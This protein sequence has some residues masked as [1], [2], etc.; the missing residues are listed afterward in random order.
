V[1]STKSLSPSK[2]TTYL[3][4]PTKYRWTYVDPRGRI[5]LR[6]KSYFSFG[7]SLHRVLQRFHDSGDTGVTTLAEATAALEESWIDAGYANAEEMTQALAE[8]KEIIS[9]YVEQVQ[10]APVTAKTLYIEKTL[11][12]PLDDFILIGRLDRVDEWEDGTLEILD[13]KTGRSGVTNE[14]AAQD[15]ALSVYQLLV[16]KHHPDR[17][18]CASIIAVRSGEKGTFSLSDSDLAELETDLKSIC[19]EILNRDYENLS[20]KVKS[21]C[22]SCD[23]LKLCRKDPDFNED[24]GSISEPSAD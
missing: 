19:S 21:L 16:K 1:A 15:L 17:P 3:A 6:S 14:E 4:C 2:I 22:P 12:A 23:F 20:P 9:S 11:K 8:G 10:K 13:Y 18:V 24:Y 5:Y 7:T